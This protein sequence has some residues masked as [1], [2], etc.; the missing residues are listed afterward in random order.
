MIFSIFSP[1]PVTAVP[2]LLISPCLGFVFPVSITSIPRNYLCNRGYPPFAGKS[3][4]LLD[5]SYS[6][7]RSSPNYHLD[8]PNIDEIIAVPLFKRKCPTSY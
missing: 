5:C 2:W 6:T 8:L 4:T 1:V 7:P 3:N